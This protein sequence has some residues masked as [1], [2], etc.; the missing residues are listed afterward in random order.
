[1]KNVEE[2]KKKLEQKKNRLNI[3]ETKLKL[4]ERKARTHQ[5]IENGGLITKTGLD[6]LPTNALYGALL[7]LK[8]QINDN[9]QIIAAWIV[10]GDKAFNAEKKTF[11]PVICKFA[12]E[13][14]KE[15]R[16]SIRSLGLRWNKFRQ[17]WYGNIQNISALK[18][19]IEDTQHELEILEENEN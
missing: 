7:S 5:L 4:K 1:M 19:T 12:S 16:D 18:K 8:E 2:Q 13:P 6:H 14:I 11:T 15:I 17:E 10:K 3:E 9:D